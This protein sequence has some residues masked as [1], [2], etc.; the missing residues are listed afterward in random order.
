MNPG[1]RVASGLAHLRRLSAAAGAPNP[2]AAPPPP[3]AARPVR[4]YRR[5]S[6]L[7]GFGGSVP[8]TLNEYIMEGRKLSKLDLVRCAKELRKYRRY[9]HALEVRPILARVQ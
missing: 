8:K 2:A 5:L 6:P 3:E 9:E 4:I 7:A 1:R